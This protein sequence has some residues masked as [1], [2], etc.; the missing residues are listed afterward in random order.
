MAV[1]AEMGGGVKELI[2][3]TAK[4]VVVL[5][6]LY[7]LILVIILTWRFVRCIT[8]MQKP[9]VPQDL[10]LISGHHFYV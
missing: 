10:S 2:P 9:E 5:H 4:N 6:L 8:W 3:T 7:L 1:L